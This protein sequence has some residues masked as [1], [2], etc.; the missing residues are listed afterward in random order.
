[1]LMIGYVLEKIYKIRSWESFEFN[2]TVENWINQIYAKTFDSAIVQSSRSGIS[3]DS[4]S[5]F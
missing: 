4:R 2:G 5:S 1:M 3:L